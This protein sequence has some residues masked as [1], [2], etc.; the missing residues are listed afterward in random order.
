MADRGMGTIFF[1]TSD[2]DDEQQF[3]LAHELAHF[4]LDYEVPRQ[5]SVETFGAS[6]LPVLDGD[7]LPTP[8]E[9]L[10]AVMSGISLGTM[11]H[12]MER[13]DDGLPAHIVLDV[14][15]RADRLALELLAPAALLHTLMRQ[16]SAPRGFNAR[17]LFLTQHLVD[18]Y[19]LP[20]A[21]AS[22]YA[23]FLLGQWGEPT[24]RDWLFG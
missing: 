1:D 16:E 8:A 19:G 23:R 22:S 20:A 7:R 12:F 14:E 21:I 6:I 13:P 11:C 10:H 17:L 3:T 9:R 18:E 15:S 5:R 4:L 24:F 2:T